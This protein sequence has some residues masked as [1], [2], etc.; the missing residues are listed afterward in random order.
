MTWEEFRDMFSV[1]SSQVADEFYPKGKSPAGKR[2]G[3]YLRDQAMLYVKLS[4]ALKEKGL[5]DDDTRPGD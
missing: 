2:R 4:Q 3:E 1:C 5:F